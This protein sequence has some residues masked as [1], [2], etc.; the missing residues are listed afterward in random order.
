MVVPMPDLQLLSYYNCTAFSHNIHTKEKEKHVFF[1]L[2]F[3][4]LLNFYEYIFKIERQNCA[5]CINK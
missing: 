3:I 1:L 4:S 5:K 2:F